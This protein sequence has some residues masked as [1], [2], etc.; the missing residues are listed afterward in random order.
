MLP[1]VLSSEPIIFS[2]L[3]LIQCSN[4]PVTTFPGYVE[5]TWQE[6]VA[7]DWRDNGLALIYL[8]L[9]NSEELLR[10][11]SLGNWKVLCLGINI[12]YPWE[13][14]DLSAWSC[15]LLKAAPLDRSPLSH[16]IQLGNWAV[17]NFVRCKNKKKLTQ[18]AFYAILNILGFFSHF[19][20]IIFGEE[21]LF[22]PW[23]FPMVWIDFDW[24]FPPGIIDDWCQV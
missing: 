8:L 12:S 14:E 5:G 19:L 16:T 9:P 6:C 18:V 17:G 3:W 1:S 21:A 22:S 24:S 23:P 15:E 13:M 20:F 2:L 7:S 4:N 11:A 10:K